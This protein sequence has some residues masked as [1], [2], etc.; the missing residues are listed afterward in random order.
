MRAFGAAE[1]EAADP[2]PLVDSAEMALVALARGEAEAPLRTAL[3]LPAGTLLTMPGR[4]TSAGSAI[5]KLVSVVPGNIE[6]NKPAIHGLAVL[7]DAGSGAP[8]AT[9][10][11]AALTAVRTAAVTAAALR[12]LGAHPR[13]LALLGS[14]AQAVR[15]ALLLH[16]VFRLHRVTVWSPTPSH[17]DQCATRLSR[18]L[19]AP[20]QA[21]ET[22]AGAASDADLVVCATTAAA[23]FLDASML[24]PPVTV[25]A[26]GAFTAQMAEVHPTVFEAAGC[27]YVDDVA[28]VM[29]EGGD[30]L[31]AIEAGAIHQEN[32][33]P[34]GGEV[35]RGASVRLFKSVGSAVEDAAVAAA[36]AG[37]E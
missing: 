31:S 7:F 4:L 27:V 37:V 8:I 13:R 16:A 35:D 28:A 12:R 10:D 2:I 17:R 32:V 30:V 9:F 26:I 24:S 14:G 29:H 15:H 11:G 6:R 5:V 22:V 23:P 21:E 1:I 18:E 33:L 3:T 36:I 20:V 34:V 19:D 25:A